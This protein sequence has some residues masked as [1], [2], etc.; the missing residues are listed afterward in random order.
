MSN[1]EHTEPNGF[2]T[3]REVQ[4]ALRYRDVHSVYHL[5]ASGRLTAVRVGRRYL[6]PAQSLRHLLS[7]VPTQTVVAE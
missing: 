4:G 2:L 7:L 6:I 5:V 1:T 3:A